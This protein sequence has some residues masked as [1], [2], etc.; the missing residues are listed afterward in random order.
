MLEKVLLSKLF[1]LSCIGTLYSQNCELNNPFIIPGSSINQTY[2]S[3]KI[4]E[5]KPSYSDSDILQLKQL[6]NRCN[7]E[8]DN[9]ISSLK[10]TVYSLSVD[11]QEIIKLKDLNKLKEQI[12]EKERSLANIKKQIETDLQ[13]VSYRG[14]FL[15]ILK[16]V[17]PYTDSKEKLSQKAD[18]LITPEAVQY[19]NGTFIKS[20]TIVMDAVTISDYIKSVISGEMILDKSL[21]NRIVT[22]NNQYIYLAKV[23]VTPLKKPIKQIADNMSAPGSSVLVIN[24]MADV[25]FRDKLLNFGISAEQINEIASEYS[26]A[27]ASLEV[28]NNLSAQQEKDIIQR[29]TFNTNQIV[30]EIDE[31][32]EQIKNRSGLLK[33]VIESKTNVVYDQTDASVNAALSY[34]DAKI[35][36][37]NKSILDAK[38]GEF[39]FKTDVPVPYEGLPGTD[40]AKKTV[41]ISNQLQASYS[42]I[43]KF[44]ETIEVDNFKVTSYQSGQSKDIYRSIDKV[45][46]YPVAGDNDN[47]KLTVVA[48]FKITGEKVNSSSAISS[49]AT[50]TNPEGQASTPQYKTVKIGEQ[51]WMAE[52]LNVDRFKNGDPIPE[53]KSDAEWKNAATYGKPAWCYFENNPQYGTT[54]GKLYNWYAVNDPRGLAPEGWRVASRTDWLAIRFFHNG[55][56]LAAELKS[57]GWGGTNS[58]GFSVSSTGERNANYETEEFGFAIDSKGCAHWWTKTN[59]DVIAAYVYSLTGYDK[60]LIEDE[61]TKG[62]G[63]AVRCVKNK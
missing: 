37:T 51:I 22:K 46:I 23:S 40:I 18:A 43:E 24:M 57:Q 38:A 60:E 58:L 2:I 48:K 7:L 6:M 10:N 47:Y 62:K 1:V 11:K 52:N 45:W 14:V 19:L 32:K 53:A 9:R 28:E 34:L 59:I 27:L 29:G 33:K 61:A 49:T 17:D 15:V 3:A 25:A 35:S 50:T 4:L 44:L 54:R 41:E 42:K 8:M 30:K 21:I 55:P 39:I 31:L 12:Q 20:M 16:N 26:S 5:F 63:F 36:E 13:S 56:N